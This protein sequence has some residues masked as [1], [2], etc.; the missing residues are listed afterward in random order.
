MA[1]A[2]FP[3]QVPFVDAS[4]RIDFRWL[5]VLQGLVAGLPP[6]GSGF[7]IDGSSTTFGPMVLYQGLDSAKPGVPTAGSI[8]FAL[9]TGNIWAAVGGTWVK[10]DPALTGDITKPAGSSVTTLATVFGSPGTYGS[11]SLTP[12]LTIDEKGRITGLVMQPITATASPGGI[13]GSIQFNNLGTLDGS[14]TIFFDPT[15]NALVFSNPAPTRE[16]LSPLTV[17]GDIFVRNATASTRLPIGTDGQ[18]LI[19]DSAEATGLRW[20]DRNTVEVRFDFGDATPK[21][22][23]TVPANR[24][25]RAASI[26]ILTAFDDAAA[27][28]ELGTPD[29][30]MEATDSAPSMLGTYGTEP[31]VQYG[32]DTLVEL[33]IT[34][35]TSTQG[36]GLVTIQLEGN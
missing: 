18:V 7:V 8:Y 32:I 26:N 13:D 14:T 5:R 16:N 24:V 33:T 35:G 20:V 6:S 25:V 10:L 17:K 31:S 27:T 15:T 36:S 2:Q 1:N 4:D 23:V 21:P 22:I 19:A 9:D 29:D 12:T 28:L 30:L 3:T 11:S 34:A